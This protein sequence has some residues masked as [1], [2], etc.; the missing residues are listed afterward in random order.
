MRHMLPAPMTGVNVWKNTGNGF[1]VFEAHYLADPAKRDPSYIEPIKASMPLNKFR[2]EFCLV[3]ESFIGMPVYP[4]FNKLV[5]CTESKL[6]P[7]IGVPLLLGLDQGLHPAVVVAQ[8]IENDMTIYKE[9][10]AS[11]MGAERFCE[12]VATQLRK[13]FP[14][15]QSFKQ[16]FI[17]AIDPTA[18]NRRDVDERSYAVVWNEAGFDPQPGE[19]FWEK[20]RTS[21]EDWLIKFRK[22]DPCF[23]VLQNECPILVEGFE[24]GYRYP[25]GA[26]DIEPK[27]ARP[28]KDSYSQPHDALQYI[29][30]FMQSRST[31]KKT[32]IPKLGY[33][34]R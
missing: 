4:D 11:N 7:K 15:W 22:G 32:V 20:R 34:N 17:L 27:K 9:Y 28:V 23:K 29:L 2:Q 24:G 13:D 16:D 8:L 5:H 18:F 10:T 12:Y 26:M 31:L 30:S 14:P 21:V 19:N 33:F 6:L 1:V 3:W 25:D